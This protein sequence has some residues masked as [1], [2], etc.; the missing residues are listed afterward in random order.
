MAH[1]FPGIML[2]NKETVGPFRRKGRASQASQ[3]AMGDG[4]MQTNRRQSDPGAR[5]RCAPVRRVRIQSTGRTVDESVAKSPNWFLIPIIR[6]DD[7]S[8][9][10][11]F[12]FDEIFE[13]SADH[14]KVRAIWP[15]AKKSTGSAFEKGTVSSRQLPTVRLAHG[16]V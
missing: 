10:Q 12:D 16:E 11:K 15:G 7:F 14:L 9:R 3:P 1:D 2:G 13:S 5:Q 4:W 8:A 6:A